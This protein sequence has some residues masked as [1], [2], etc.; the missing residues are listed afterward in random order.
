MAASGS[1]I[2][3]F[4]RE[5]AGGTGLATLDAEAEA[6]GPGGGGPVPVPPL[7]RPLHRPGL[8]PTADV[9]RAGADITLI[10]TS[11]MVQVAL[12]AAETLAEGGIEAEVVDPRPRR[13]PDRA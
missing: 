8:G 11:S 12:K 9:K 13:E 10:A 5:L 3:W 4:Q 7:A 2:R 1:V 6:A